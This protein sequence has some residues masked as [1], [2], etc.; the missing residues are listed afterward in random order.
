MKTFY[1][2]NYRKSTRLIISATF[3]LLIIFCLVSCARKLTFGV[4]PVVPAAEGTVKIK[5]SKNGNYLVNVKIKNLAGPRRLSPPREVY[6][7]W[8]QSDR[9][10]PKN[11]GMI[12]TSSGLFSSTLKGEM[13]AT[14]I[15]KPTG[16]FI[17]AEDDGNVRYPGSQVVLRTE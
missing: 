17:T 11:L 8:M 2:N 6:V 10:A 13:N 5:K 3:L 9:N 16:I 7:V 12:K 15:T 4:S 1:I 14:A